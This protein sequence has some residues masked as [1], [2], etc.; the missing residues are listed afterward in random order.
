M[1]SIQMHNVQLTRN[2]QPLFSQLNLTLSEA[3]IGLIGSNGA[4]KSS[5]AQL[6]NGLL[7]PDKGQVICHGIDT[8]QGPQAL[9]RTIGYV[10]QNSDHQMIFPTVAEELAFSLQQSGH[11]QPTARAGALDYLAQ[12]HRVEWADR[13]VMSLS[14]GQKQWLCIH[15]IVIMAPKVLILDE[16]YA[17]LDLAS[18]YALSALLK[19]LPQQILLITHEFE[20]LAHFDRI[21]WL[22]SGQIRADASPSEVLP[23]YCAQASQNMHISSELLRL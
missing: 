9:A 13:S 12:Q 23:E 17:A 1:L 3:R 18:R 21:I 15:A 8:H 11:S 5:L 16:P 10:F 2:Q 22:E 20:S 14:E 19:S 4:G 7:R 6:C